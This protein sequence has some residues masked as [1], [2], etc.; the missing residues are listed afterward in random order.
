[1]MLRML[2][3]VLAHTL[4][5]AVTRTSLLQQIPI[6]KTYAVLLISSSGINISLN[7]ALVCNRTF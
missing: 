2:P 1:M 6:F 7:V 3:I 4:V 5:S